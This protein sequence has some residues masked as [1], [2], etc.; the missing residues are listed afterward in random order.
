MLRLVLLTTSL[1]LFGCASSRTSALVASDSSDTVV[2][3]A[4]EA[5]PL[6]QPPTR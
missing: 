5:E 1:T 3:L 6:A 2:V 4:P